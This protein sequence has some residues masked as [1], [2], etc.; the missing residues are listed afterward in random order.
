[1]NYQN[2][3]DAAWQMLIKNHISS[4]PVSVNNICKSEHIRLFTYQEG[5]RV[6]EQ[7]SL[8]DHM[9]ENDAFSF[10]HMIFFDDRQPITRQ[11]F[12]VAHELGHIVLHPAV[13]A[14]VLNREI[15][16]N[17][18]PLETEANIFASRLLA[19]LCILHFLNLNSPQQIAE[20]CQIS[21]IAAKIRYQRLCDIRKRDE[22]MR[23][24]KGYGCFLLSPLEQQVYRNFENYIK[25][26]E[27]N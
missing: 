24:K 6:I 3:R 8:Q 2:S 17:D 21:M 4:L 7:L 23:S 22:R 5:K 1:M 15:S 11:R 27:I 26:N 19:P 18:S 25:S 13:E 12:S 20:L 10:C 14:T 9:H 16:P